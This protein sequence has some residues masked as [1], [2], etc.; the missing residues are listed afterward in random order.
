MRFVREIGEHRARFVGLLLAGLWV[1]LALVV[2]HPTLAG[3]Y[4]DDGIYLATARSLAEGTGYRQI[5]LPT[6]PWQTKYPP[7][8]PA[9]LAP[10]WLLLPGFPANVLAFKAL[11]AVCVG[12]AALVTQRL[13]RRHGATSG[14]SLL[15]LALYLGSWRL[16][17]GANFVLSEPAFT[18]FAL[19]AVLLLEEDGAHDR[20]AAFRIALGA[21]ALALAVLTRGQGLVVVAAAAAGLAVRRRWRPLAAVVA[22]AALAVGGWTAWRRAHAGPASELLDYYV[23]YGSFLGAEGA[24][25]ASAH[26]GAVARR[27]ALEV[28]AALADLVVAGP[29][30]VLLLQG[31]VLLALAAV[32]AV[33]LLRSGRPMLPLYALGGI[34]V[35]WLLPWSPDRIAL[36]ALPALLVLAV[37]G[38]RALVERWSETRRPLARRVAAAGAALVLA[39]QLAVLAFELRVPDGDG[40]PHPR[41]LS[42]GR[43]EWPGYREAFEWV[44]ANV[45]AGDAIAAAHD[46][47]WYLY[48][49]RRAVRFW[50]FRPAEIWLEGA[51]GRPARLGDPAALL[52]ELDRLGVRWLVVEEGAAD[53][54]PGG[55]EANALARRILALPEA[56][57]R[58]EHDVPAAGLEIWRLHADRAA[59]RGRRVRRGTAGSAQGA[60]AAAAGSASVTNRPA[61]HQAPHASSTPG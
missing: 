27:H 51:T 13:A 45:P 19:L 57:A 54:V 6:E 10:I 24:G 53:L 29:Y 40:L 21:A 43:G 37:G 61:H 12:L 55:R 34:V 18:L 49:G 47:L 38:G 16:L 33:R 32:G 39:A 23:S 17:V 22:V 42:S 7:V 31:V 25:Q 3:A 60:G 35:L 44:R 14:E 58:R 41:A 11:G 56:G 36:P 5:Q 1:V 4:H 15:V 2:V 8:W 26:P 59:S 28:P 30:P 52:T 9:M 48:T 46:P 50:R 20:R